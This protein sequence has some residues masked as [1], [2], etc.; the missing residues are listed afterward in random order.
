MSTEVFTGGVRRLQL[1]YFR[2]NGAEMEGC[3]NLFLECLGR[4]REKWRYFGGEK[5][6]LAEIAHNGSFSFPNR[7]VEQPGS[8]SGS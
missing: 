3:S 7:G 5:F 1:Q 2:M 6:S 8:S 4:S